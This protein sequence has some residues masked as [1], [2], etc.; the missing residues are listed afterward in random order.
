MMQQPLAL[1]YGEQVEKA[2][3]VLYIPPAALRVD[4]ENFSGPLDLLLYLVRK[5]KFD[6]MD[7]PMAELCRQYAEYTREILNHDLETAADYLAMASLLLEIKSKTLLPQPIENDDEEDP[8][9]DLVRRLLE[10]ERLR[11]VALQICDMPRRWRDFSSPQVAVKWPER[12]MLKPVLQSAQL[13]LAYATVTAR[14]KAKVTYQ[15]LRET[16]TVREVMSNILRNC[17]GLVKRFGRR[18][19]FYRLA[20][21][22]YLGISF[23]ALL[24]LAAENTVTLIQ[25]DTDSELFV[26]WH[27][28][29]GK[30]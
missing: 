10:Y 13:A 22:G 5:Q 23:L 1:V 7:I 19:E 14:E 30:H 3:E 16:V 29:D 9:A 28:D 11:S 2:P 26:E 21:P 25:D 15:I 18:L 8:R 17:M 6:I 27:N 4:L 20:T 24:H 12:P